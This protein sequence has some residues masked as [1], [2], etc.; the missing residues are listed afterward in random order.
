M[1]MKNMITTNCCDGITRR[2]FVR[3]G[4]LSAMGLGLGSFFK[5]Q[6][7]AAAQ[8]IS[9]EAK[10]KSCILIWL[11][12]GPSHIETFDPKPDAPSEVR[13][14]FAAIDTNVSGIQLSECLE[15]TAQ[16]MDKIALIRSM[17]SP[18]RNGLAPS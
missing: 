16:V 2:D 6:S 15:R 14:P 7:A 3:I 11:E 13:G 5:L 18:L 8:K 12:G 9:I 1:G 10:A 17:T 4:G